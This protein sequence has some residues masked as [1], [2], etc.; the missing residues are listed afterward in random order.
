MAILRVLNIHQSVEKVIIYDSH[1]L[2]L[3]SFLR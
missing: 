3:A 1:T 2:S